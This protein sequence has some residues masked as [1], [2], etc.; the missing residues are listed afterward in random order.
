MSGL[1]KLFNIHFF[2]WWWW[3]DFV[4]TPRSSQ[5]SLKTTVSFLVFS[6]ISTWMNPLH[7]S[8]NCLPR[9][10]QYNQASAPAFSI[11]CL[12]QWPHYW[13]MSLWSRSPPRLS[14]L[15][16]SQPWPQGQE[17]ISVIYWDVIT[18]RQ[19][20]QQTPR[21]SRSPALCECGELSISRYSNLCIHNEF[22]IQMSP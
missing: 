4:F 2:H 20:T 18:Y 21:L 6:H 1:M 8:S 16:I 12:K 3:W 10:I 15:P 11:S 19:V 5:L 7:L 22:L 9:V 14:C 13:F 17:R